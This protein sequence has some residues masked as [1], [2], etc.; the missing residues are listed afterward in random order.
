MI[1]MNIVLLIYVLIVIFGLRFRK[2]G[3]YLDKDSTCNVKGIFTIMILLSH[4]VGY[5]NID[6]G[7]VYAKFLA[8]FGQLMV[9]MFLF[10][11]GYGIMESLKNKKDYMKSFF[12]KRFLKVFIHFDLAVIIYLVIALILKENHSIKTYFLSFLAWDDIGNSNWYIFVMLALYLLTLV[13]YKI[14]SNKKKCFLFGVT[15]FSGI[16]IILLYF[17]K[18][19]WWYNIILC[20]PCGMWYSYFKDQ[21]EKIILMKYK[22]IS[23]VLVL[24]MFLVLHHYFGNIILYEMLACI[25]CLLVVNFTYVFSVGN[26]ILAFFGKY[27]FQIYILQRAVYKILLGKFSNVVLYFGVSLVL[28]LFISILFKCLTDKIDKKLFS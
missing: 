9:T 27:A 2:G 3:Y 14:F 11:S 1:V 4:F 15:F 21:I 26:R 12:K 22:Y 7:S 17:V 25:F 28:I 20:Y 6:S 10:Y 23:L 18:D 24:I 19:V 16:L 13:S 5:A 8:Y